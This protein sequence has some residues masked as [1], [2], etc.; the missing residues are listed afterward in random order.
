MKIWIDLDNSPHVPFFIP[1]RRE[2]EKQGHSVFLTTRDCFQVCSLAEYH[3][4]K[5]TTVGKHYGANR[6]LKILGTMWRGIQ[7]AWIIR[8]RRFD[9]SLSHGSRSLIIAS[10]L[11]KIPTMVLFDYEHAKMLPFI[12]PTL[13]MA[14]E[15][16]KSSGI[17]KRFKEGLRWYEGLKED[18][19]VESFKPDLSILKKLGL[20][21]G[22]LIATIRPPATEAHYHNPE[23]EKIFVEVVEFLGE[24]PNLRMVI[25]PRNEK[26]QREMIFKTWPKLCSEHRIIVPTDPIAGLDLIWNSDFVVSGGGTMN[27]EAAALCVPVYSIF[28]GK[29]GAVDRYLA[30]KGRLTFIESVEEVRKKIKPICREKKAEFDFKGRLALRQIVGGIQEWAKKNR[31][32]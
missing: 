23:A 29:I 9:F 12:K 20:K 4:L 21:N 32:E 15:V 6:I 26:T 30:D 3:G 28:K 17:E 16:I 31:L 13:G 1:I 7:L 11:L 27:R 24:K 19:Y 8:N 10:A 5:H 25:L 14:P 2:L 22:D 18:V